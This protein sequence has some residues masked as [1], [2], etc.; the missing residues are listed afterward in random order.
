MSSEAAKSALPSVSSDD[1]RRACGRFATGVA[2]ASV[3]DESGA[4]HGLTISS[5]T[6]VS[7]EP[8]LVLICLGHAVTNIEAF[9]RAS[10]FGINV[11]R[12]EDRQVSQHFATKGHDRF[13]G[14][15]WRPGK[16]GVP[17]IDCALAAFESETYQRIPSG[18]HDILLG[19]VVHTRVEEGA[20]LL[21]FASRYR[22]LALD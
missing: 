22:A 2:I 6:S 21:F 4:A 1:F 9:R 13:N 12:E 15:G 16:T 3:I 20:P 5:F 18:D 8:P 7:L 10:Y 19:R 11:L 17:V 14:V